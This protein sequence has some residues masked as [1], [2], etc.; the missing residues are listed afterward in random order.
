MPASHLAMHLK[1]SYTCVVIQVC[2]APMHRGCL[3]RLSELKRH[4]RIL[5]NFTGGLER[6][7]IHAYCA[8]CMAFF[9]K[10]WAMPDKFQWHIMIMWCDFFPPDKIFL[11]M[12][13]GQ[14]CKPKSFLKE[15]RSL[16]RLSFYTGASV[17]NKKRHQR[18]SADQKPTFP[19]DI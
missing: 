4:R 17:Y 14:L 13:T 9:A 11:R 18:A 12:D 8:F 5:R 10:A 2:N 15:E 19:G 16:P 1:V 7:I 3:E 6:L